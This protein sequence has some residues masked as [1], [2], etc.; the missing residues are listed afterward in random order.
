MLLVF[1][2]QHPFLNCTTIPGPF[3]SKLAVWSVTAMQLAMTGFLPWIQVF[4]LHDI[5]NLIQRSSRAVYDGGRSPENLLGSFFLQ[6]VFYSSFGLKHCMVPRDLAF[7]AWEKLHHLRHSR[8]S[9]AATL[10]WGFIPYYCYCYCYYHY[11]SY[12]FILFIWFPPSWN[13]NFCWRCTG[14]EAQMI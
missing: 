14:L 12:Y 1:F 4:L 5:R 3:W 8:V 9:L 13:D 6:L 10:L 7:R 11:C 2:T